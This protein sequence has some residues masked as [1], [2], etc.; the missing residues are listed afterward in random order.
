MTRL[1]V[2]SASGMSVAK[3]KSTVGNPLGSDMIYRV[4][5]LPL[6]V[7]DS[8]RPE[9]SQAIPTGQASR[10][11]DLLIQSIDTARISRFSASKGGPPAFLRDVG[12]PLI[13]ARPPGNDLKEEGFRFV[14]VHEGSDYV[15]RDGGNESSKFGILQTTA[16]RYGFRGSVG[17][18]LRQDAEAIYEKIWEESGAANLPRELALVHFDTYV[19]S[20]AAAKKMLRSSDGSPEVYLDLRSQRYKRLSHMKPERYGKYV[21]G[22]MNRIENLRSLIAEDSHRPSTRVPT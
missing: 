18:M 2:P 6:A 9:S 3:R 21:R 15:S 16:N 10:F 22:W 5:S 20:P 14:F 19:N 11:L 7:I 1:D 4:P 12:F 8:G 17:D 13:E